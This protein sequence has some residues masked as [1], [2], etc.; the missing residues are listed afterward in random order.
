MVGRAFLPVVLAC[1]LC[2]ACRRDF[3]RAQDADD[4]VD[5]REPEGDA[6]DIVAR[7]RK[8]LPRECPAVADVCLARQQDGWRIARLRY[9]FTR[10]EDLTDSNLRPL[11]NLASLGS[12]QL[13]AHWGTE[14]GYFSRLTPQGLRDLGRLRLRR[15]VFPWNT[16]DAGVQAICSLRE[17]EDLQLGSFGSTEKAMGDRGL[18]HLRELTNLRRLALSGAELGDASLDSI[19][20][21]SNLEELD[22]HLS[23]VM[24]DTA[25]VKLLG[26][27]HL[28]LLNLGRLSAK[29]SSALRDLPALEHLDGV[30]LE[31][32]DLSM[33]NSLKQLGTFHAGDGVPKPVPLP[34]NL[35]ELTLPHSTVAG[36]D[37]KSCRNLERVR[38]DVGR[39]WND[40]GRPGSLAWLN[41]LPKLT[42]LSLVG[43]VDQDVKAIAGL[44]SLRALT[45]SGACAVKFSDEG[46][47]ALAGWRQLESLE[48]CEY[49]GWV[50]DAGLDV[51]RNFE[52][53]RRLDLTGCFEVPS[54]G[55]GVT[56]KGLRVLGELKQLR[57]LKLN[58]SAERSMAEVLARVSL[59]AHLEDL[60]IN[61]CITDERLRMLEGLKKL[62]RLDLSGSRG[63]TDDGLRMLLAAVPSLKQ[64]E[65]EL[66]VRDTE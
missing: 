20:S 14:E 19:G 30:P 10:G 40:N 45:L 47:R 48:I 7:C 11:R 22:L 63:Y 41:S 64:L 39:H 1:L 26:L 66:S 33:L 15:F 57:V 53:L 5:E 38:I 28:R 13:N 18:V 16:T 58:L 8:A 60:T 44:S 9:E 52:K 3:E 42:H 17:V 21:L 43:A 32:A 29:D 55:L 2:A 25:V 35:R 49:G 4:A 27:R 61:G 31:T 50:S 23:N 56:A 24:T 46:L 54:E 36:L 37:L 51:L 62:R 65:F 12:L 59:L 34:E 6:S